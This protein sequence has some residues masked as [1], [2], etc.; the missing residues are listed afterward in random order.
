M[1]HKIT[2]PSKPVAALMLLLS[3]LLLY[4]PGCNKCEL[5]EQVVTPPVK[6]CGGKFYVNK[7]EP[8]VDLVFSLHEFP[9]PVPE[10]FA[11]I[12]KAGPL[13]VPAM[14]FNTKSNFSA[15][16]STGQL[17]VYEHYYGTGAQF[18]SFDA[19]S[20]TPTHTPGPQIGVCP[21]FHKGRLYNIYS[22]SFGGNDWFYS[23]NEINPVTGQDGVGLT[24]NTITSDIPLFQEY[25]S[26]VSTGGDLIYFISITNLIEYRVS[27]N[28]T[29]HMDIDPSYHPI[30]NPVIY[31]G[32]EYKRDEGLLLAMRNKPNSS[33]GSDTE[34]VSI[35]V[36]STGAVV[37]GIFDISANMPTGQV[38]TV[39]NEFYSSTF[40][41]C[42]NIY[43]VTSMIGS[44]ILN[45]NFIEINLS[46]N[47]LK[48]QV[49]N[50]Y[51]YGL[52]FV[53]E[54]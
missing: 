26:S 16:D 52:E 21:V 29:R 40:D 19:A 13:G 2:I 44:E 1:T 46:K 48:L 12:A 47:E 7:A 39:N 54:P 11:S 25:M 37:T 17:Y 6:T 8:G 31:F 4:L 53:E 45:T 9:K 5:L 18:F 33:G 20:G 51:W 38:K 49:L 41:Q 32:L 36:S 3:T 35:N 23:I 34:L 30:D 42:D 10:P 27:N 15:Y 22:E 24:G 50:D 28:T 43:F 14:L